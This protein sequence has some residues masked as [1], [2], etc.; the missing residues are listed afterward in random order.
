MYTYDSFITD[1]FHPIFTF[2]MAMSCGQALIG[3]WLLLK[4]RKT[5]FANYFL[6][7]WF[8]AWGGSCYFSFADISGMPFR[9]SWLPFYIGTVIHIL[10][11]PPLYLYA[12]Y[13]L[14][15]I[16]RFNYKDLIHFLPVL[17]YYLFIAYIISQVGF[18]IEDIRHS[19]LYKVRMEVFAYISSIQ[20]FLYYFTT[21]KLIHRQK[22]KLKQRFSEIEEMTLHW[23][24]I[25]NICTFFVVLLSGLSTLTRITPFDPALL[26][27]IY[28]LFIMGAIYYVSMNLITKPIVLT[29][30]RVVKKKEE[31]LQDSGWSEKD[32]LK[33]N[34]SHIEPQWAIDLENSMV[35][36]KI[37]QDQDLDL[38]ELASVLH[39][40]RN[41]LSSLL[42]EVIGKSF[43]EYVNE[44]RLEECKQ[45]LSN[46]KYGHLSALSIGLTSGFRSKS[47][48]YRI[49]KEK[50]GMTPTKYREIFEKK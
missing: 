32:V 4:H 47:V 45:K 28:D 39:L 46:P 19:Y 24:K 41:Q 38:Q 29:G 23:I 11:F 22:D 40:S 17:F 50:E 21:K 26:Y 18:N 48:F 36:Q 7:L 2:L 44:W 31:I 30:V 6:A 49:F 43:Y 9:V 15:G 1:Y 3:I 20:G 14:Y 37:Y 25:L 12:K 13:I 10:L 8:A 16:K 27:N 34:H 5:Q 35:N 33:K 42:N